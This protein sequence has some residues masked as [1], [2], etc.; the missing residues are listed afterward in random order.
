MCIS[1]RGAGALV[2]SGGRV[3]T[4]LP[5]LSREGRSDEECDAQSERGRHFGGCNG[6]HK[7]RA[8]LHR[9]G[10]VTQADEVQVFDPRGDIDATL[11]Q[12]VYSGQC[13]AVHGE[14]YK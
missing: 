3:Q 8:F 10:L 2:S 5:Q 11:N 4:H 1:S 12:T 14:M 6:Q 13:N 7:C 9:C